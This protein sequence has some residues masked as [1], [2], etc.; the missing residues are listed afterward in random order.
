M[1][2]QLKQQNL[3]VTLANHGREAL[4]ILLAAEK[5]GTGNGNAIGIVLM[6]IEVRTRCVVS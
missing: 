5:N 6:D 3:Q 1:Q 2:R 4:D